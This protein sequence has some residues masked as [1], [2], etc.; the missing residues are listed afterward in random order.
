MPRQQ[1]PLVAAAL[2]YLELRRGSW[3]TRAAALRASN[4]RRLREADAAEAAALERLAALRASLA[5]S[6]EV[7]AMAR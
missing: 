4:M 3:T 7:S 2:E 6:T 5:G 1:A